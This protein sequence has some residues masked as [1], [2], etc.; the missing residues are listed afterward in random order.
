MA[1][2]SHHGCSVRDH[3]LY[4][5]FGEVQHFYFWEIRYS[6][7]IAPS[8]FLL[9]QKIRTDL[10]WTT[11]LQASKNLRKCDVAAARCH[12]TRVPDIRPTMEMTLD[13]VWRFKRRQFWRRWNVESICVVVVII[14]STS[15]DTCSSDIVCYYTIPIGFVSPIHILWPIC[16]SQ[17]RWS[18]LLRSSVF[19]LLIVNSFL[20]FHIIFVR[21]FSDFILSVPLKLLTTYFCRWAYTPQ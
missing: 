7:D 14:Y 10:K 4:S 15:L 2:S 18:I 6:P 9:F 5:S 3:G 1:V 11:D 13:K 21:L 19:L 12:R 8:E 16:I 17:F 20:V